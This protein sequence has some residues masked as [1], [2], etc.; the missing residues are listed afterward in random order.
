MEFDRFR[1]IHQIGYIGMSIKILSLV[2]VRNVSKV[3]VKLLP[4]YEMLIEVFGLKLTN[5]YWIIDSY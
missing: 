5:G 2:Y 1:S 4:L 3:Y